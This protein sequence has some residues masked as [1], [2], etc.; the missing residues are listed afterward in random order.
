MATNNHDE[1]ETPFLRSSHLAGAAKVGHQVMPSLSSAGGA[2]GER[3]VPQV[4]DALASSDPE[5]IY[6]SIP[7][8]PDVNDGF[9]D[10]TMQDLANAVNN[11]AW[12]LE[13]IEGKPEE[14]RFERIAYIGASDIRYAIMMIAAIKVGYVVSIYPTLDYGSFFGL[15]AHGMFND[16]GG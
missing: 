1:Q 5:R 14:G 16:G 15:Y 7:L 4:L 8:T 12:M 13:G 6:A 10:V 9:R 3:L 11:I 2:Y